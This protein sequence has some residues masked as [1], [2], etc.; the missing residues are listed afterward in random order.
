MTNT[1][2][3]LL[4][5]NNNKTPTITMIIITYLAQLSD[6]CFTCSITDVHFEDFS[7]HKQL[8]EIRDNKIFNLAQGVKEKCEEVWHACLLHFNDHSPKMCYL[9]HLLVFVHCANLDG[10]GGNVFTDKEEANSC[11]A[12]QANKWKTPPG[13]KHFCDWLKERA[14]ANLNHG[15]ML[16]AFGAH[17]CRATFHLFFILSGEDF[18]N[19]M[20][21]GR[22]LTVEIPMGCCRNAI[23][24]KDK[25]EADWRKNGAGEQRFPTYRDILVHQDGEVLQRIN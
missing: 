15:D 22:H 18:H 4:R 23:A 6:L 21:N 10:K 1:V 19:A 2:V 5:R 7:D 16:V 9:R 20:R 12:S 3:P 14:S 17:S 11:T 13:C 25:L 24:M 8:F